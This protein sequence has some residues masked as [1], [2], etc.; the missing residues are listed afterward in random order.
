LPLLRLPR[1]DPLGATTQVQGVEPPRFAF[2]PLTLL[3]AGDRAVG[4]LE[5]EAVVDGDDL[6]CRGLDAVHC[7]VDVAVV[8]V[9]VK[10][11]DGLV[12]AEAHLAEKHPDRLVHLGTRRLLTLSPAQDPMLHRL[13]APTGDLGQVDHLLDLTVVV[14]VEEVKAP[15][16]STFSPSPPAATPAM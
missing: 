2:P 3:D 16:C 10:R 1:L 6:L 14:D 15:R 9:A 7:H 8:G 4:D 12:L 11:I 5:V 13:R